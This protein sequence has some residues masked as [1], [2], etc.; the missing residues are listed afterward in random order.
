MGSCCRRMCNALVERS[1]RDD[2]PPAQ[3]HLKRIIV[4]VAAAGSFI[5]PILFLAYCRAGDQCIGKFDDV[6]ILECWA[7]CLGGLCAIFTRAPTRNVVDGMVFGSVFGI[8]LLDWCQAAELQPRMW[9]WALLSLSALH[10]A[11]GMPLVENFTLYL[12]TVWLLAER[13]LNAAGVDMYTVAF[14]GNGKPLPAPCDCASPPCPVDVTTAVGNSIGTLFVY[15]AVAFMTRGF[16]N[17]LRA[18]MRLMVSS[19]DVVEQV[20]MHLSRYEVDE[21]AHAIYLAG[22]EDALPPDLQEHCTRLVDN[23]RSYRPYLPQSCLPDS[24]ELDDA[25][26]IAG[27]ESSGDASTLPPQTTVISFTGYSGATPPE[28][29]RV[30]HSPHSSKDLEDTFSPSSSQPAGGRHRS[31]SIHSDRRSPGMTW[32][33]RYPSVLVDPHRMHSRMSSRSSLN[34]GS[35]ARG[36]SMMSVAMSPRGRAVRAPSHSHPGGGSGAVVAVPKP[37]TACLLLSNLTGFLMRIAGAHPGNLQLVINQECELFVECINQSKGVVDLLNVDHHYASF[38]AARPC[39]SRNMAAARAASLLHKRTPHTRQGSTGANDRVVA[40]C[41]GHGVC[42]DFGATVKRFMSV[43]PVCTV[44]LAAER[45]ATAWE[46]CTVAN[47]LVADDVSQVYELRL[48]EGICIIKSS[49]FPKPVLLWQV[50]AER[51]ANAAGPEEWMYELQKQAQG[52]WEG[53]NRAHDL[54]IQGKPS[55]ALAAASNAAQTPADAEVEAALQQLIERIG[56]S[57]SGVLHVQ[58]LRAVTPSVLPPVAKRL[59]R[60]GTTPT[61]ESSRG[62]SCSVKDVL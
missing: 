61:M 21:A 51:A 49:P 9:A 43:G 48:R 32:N 30:P 18:Q 34:R 16:A 26:S 27:A 10:V 36:T 53:Y 42:G 60:H 12:V 40:L 19:I 20:T 25:E 59:V 62:D 7:V 33:S 4:P 3:A 2:D 45:L 22:V 5:M 57:A 55:N 37:K 56:H 6:A 1:L 46:V 47:G 15:L 13:L 23:L 50:D 31:N 44:L 38:G 8:L 14:L 11:D 52:R 17:G 54:W 28:S 41:A 35:I 29:P 39:T 58:E 24:Q